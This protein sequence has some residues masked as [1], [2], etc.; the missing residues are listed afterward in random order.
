MFSS[1]NIETFEL[2]NVKCEPEEA[3]N[4]PV[5]CLLMIFIVLT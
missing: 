4:I 3:I 1:T 5:Y 2:I